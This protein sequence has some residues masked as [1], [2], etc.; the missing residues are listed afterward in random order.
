[1]QLA[2][3]MEQAAVNSCVDSSSSLKTG[4]NGGGDGLFHRWRDVFSKIFKHSV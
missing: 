2:C 1:V 3:H 4:L